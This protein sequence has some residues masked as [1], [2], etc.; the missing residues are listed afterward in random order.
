MYI[1][2]FLIF[3]SISLVSGLCHAIPELKGTPQDL[4][5][6]I[7]PSDNIVTIS[8]HAEEKAY[9]DRAV[10]SLVVTTEEK[11]MA[12][13][14]ASNSA[15]RERLRNSLNSA[16]IS[17]DAIKNS[18]FSSS[19]QYGW[20]GRK[21]NSYK[22]VNRVAVKIDKESQLETIARLADQNRE[23]ELSDTSFEHSLEEEYNEKVKTL[24]LQ[25]VMEQKAHYEKTLGVKLSP[26]GIRSANVD[27]QATRGAMVLEE[28]VVTGLRHEQDS[29][30]EPSGY[31][32]RPSSFDEISY[33]AEVSVDF[34]IQ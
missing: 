19:P 26:V 32:D 31:R 22:V 16:G 1:N 20:L 5:G 27:Q 7:Y 33:E 34:K 11:Q 3:V 17:R 21:P 6:L 24:A 4:R 28:V 9:S 25:R 15:L 30:S 13:A 10:V 23:V 2:K 29:Y 8:G 12:D 18:K 14:I